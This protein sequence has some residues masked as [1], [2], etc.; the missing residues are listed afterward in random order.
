MP[1]T[2]NAARPLVRAFLTLL[3][4]A[5]TLLACATP[6]RASVAA[7]QCPGSLDQPTSATLDD[8]SGAVVCL[9]NAER[10]RRGLR[11]LHRDTDLEAVGRRYSA[12]MVRHTFFAH[13]SPG[14]SDFGDRLRKVGYGTGKAWRAGE[15]LG[16]G[17]GSRSTPNT[18]VDEWL[19]SP[20]H[21]RL[22]LDAGFRELGVGVAAGAPQPVHSDL[23][24]ATFALE[25]GVVRD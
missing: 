18:L 2:A 12:A 1:L 6:A 9:V 11:T 13:V 5:C 10:A 24:A 4:G 22:L 17:T 25:L 3:A 14:G 21:R 19:A 15:A 23:A 16:W 7:A 8:A 20:G